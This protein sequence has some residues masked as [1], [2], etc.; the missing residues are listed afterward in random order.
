MK[1]GYTLLLIIIIASVLRLANIW[2][3]PPGLYPD[4]AMNG[5]NA[6]E[7]LETGNYKVF[8][9]ENNGREGLFANIEVPSVA[10]LGNEP[11][12][13]RIPS[14]VFGILTVLGVYFLT[15]EL[16][17][18]NSKIALLAA[19]L[20]ATSFWHINFSRIG[21]RAIMAPFF[22]VWA[23]YYLFLALRKLKEGK[24]T[25]ALFIYPA[26][27]GLFFGL[28]FSSYI[29]Y[30][31]MPLIFLALVPFYWRKK[32]FYAI[33]SMFLLFTIVAVLPLALYFVH[34]PADFLGRTS[35]ISVFDSASPLRAVGLNIVKTLGMFNFAGDY[36]W[37]HNV[38]GRPE[39]FWP[40][41]LLFLLGVG[42][43]IRSVFRRMFTK[44]RSEN[45]LAYTFLF[46]W[47][48]V[49][50]LPVVISNEGIPHAL[51]AILMIPPVIIFSAVGG[52]KLYR[53]LEKKLK[54]KQLLK[55]AAIAFLTLLTFEAYHTYFIK[56]GQNEEVAS[57]F[58]KEYADIAAQIN[59]LPQS[60][61]KIVVVN[62]WGVMVRGIPMPA[63]TVMFMTD[64]F[65]EKDR[66]SHNI[67]YVTPDNFSEAS[68][69]EGAA[70]F[71]IN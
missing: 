70:V 57:A 71:Q 1:K 37:R 46:T 59:E 31:I 44:K 45:V 69:P 2:S 11:Q 26:I 52:I 9:P 38:A 66:Q 68:A 20:L 32:E 10:I 53:Y 18:G 17:G 16:F 19:F 40:V 3:I 7:A 47:A 12:A 54:E 58:T 41:G 39:L 21:F 34:N 43:S 14:A 5:N 63:Q 60:T 6:V 24:K 64:S 8:Y 25:A 56:W 42:L 35:Q 4:E 67:T 62:A 51:R 36:N 50:A 33:G 22:L 49:A 15:K 28:G 55:L 13:L 30:R 61:P 65:T 27:G 23:S 48:A 29:A